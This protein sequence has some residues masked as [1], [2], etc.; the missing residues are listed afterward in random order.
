LAAALSSEEPG[1]AKW[2]FDGASE[3]T[4]R[5]GLHGADESVLAPEHFHAA[6]TE[7]LATG[8]PAWDPYDA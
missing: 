4:P 2:Q 1:G 5:L 7:A 6:L 8:E 3:L